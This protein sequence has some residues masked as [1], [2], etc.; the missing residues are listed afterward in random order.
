MHQLSATLAQRVGAL[1][2]RGYA[3]ILRLSE[4][5]RRY[6]WET[7]LTYP[8][9]ALKSHAANRELEKHPAL[10]MKKST[11]DRRRCA[12]Q[13]WPRHWKAVSFARWSNVLSI[14]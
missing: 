9:D 3:C 8:V 6:A 4:A 14:F 11:A 7:M 5:G 10:D 12:S 13:R 2:G 1:C